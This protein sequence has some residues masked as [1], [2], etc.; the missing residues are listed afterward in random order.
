MRFISVLFNTFT[1]M[2]GNAGMSPSFIWPN[3]LSG[4]AMIAIGGLFIVQSLKLA[5]FLFEKETE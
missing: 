5:E 2:R 1:I 3:V 4:L